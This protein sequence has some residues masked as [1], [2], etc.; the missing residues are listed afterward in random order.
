MQY[1][2]QLIFFIII[3]FNYAFFS[4]DRIYEILTKNLYI[5]D[6]GRIMEEIVAGKQPKSGIMCDD[7]FRS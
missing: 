7:I 2:L 3:Q 1:N 4:D 6:P 5:S